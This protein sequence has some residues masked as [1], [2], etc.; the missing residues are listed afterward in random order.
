GIEGG[1]AVL[2]VGGPFLRVA[3]RFV[4]FAQFLELLLGGFVAGIFVGM[5]FDGQLAVGFFDLL[6]AGVA[7]HSEDLVII[8]FGHSRSGVR[9]AGDHYA[10]RAD[11]PLAALVAPAP[12]PQNTAFPYS[13]RL[14]PRNRFV[15]APVA[16]LPGGRDFLQ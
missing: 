6:L 1:M 9:F 7:V 8:A 5:V 14:L 12:L 10:G 15:Q 11:E 13:R 4:G 16:A 3:Q 2:I